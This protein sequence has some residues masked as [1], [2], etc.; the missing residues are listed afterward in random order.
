[1]MACQRAGAAAHPI[2]EVDSARVASG[3]PTRT[4]VGSDDAIAVGESQKRE[5]ERDSPLATISDQK[6]KPNK[7]TANKHVVI[8]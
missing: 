1:M 7:T 3:E 4:V 8:L 6:R 2:R 5:R